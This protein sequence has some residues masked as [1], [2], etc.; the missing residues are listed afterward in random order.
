MKSQNEHKIENV[1]VVVQDTPVTDSY[2]SNQP[3]S[4]IVVTLLAKT[5]QN[6]QNAGD[7]VLQTEGGTKINTNQTIGEAGIKSG[8]TLR[9]VLKKDGVVA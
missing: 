5:K 3:L 8:E 9:L 7:W 2:N 1:T 6:P 4:A